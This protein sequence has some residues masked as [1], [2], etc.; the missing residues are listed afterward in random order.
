[1]GVVSVGAGRFPHSGE[2]KWRDLKGRL[3]RVESHSHIYTGVTG[4]AFRLFGPPDFVTGARQLV[5]QMMDGGDLHVYPGY[6]L[7]G[8]SV[9][10][11]GRYLD[12]KT[13]GWPG[14]V[15]DSVYEAIRTRRAPIEMRQQF[16]ALYRDMLLDFGAWRATAEACYAG[17]RL[18]GASSAD[19]E[20][21]EE[22]AL[23][24]VA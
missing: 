13:S 6:V 24:T 23:R 20:R 18:F 14:T 3:W 10:L 1:M 16:D 2:P 19:P 8:S 21:G 17:L 15:H 22:Y 11:L 4:C 9:P 12:N 7:D 5:V